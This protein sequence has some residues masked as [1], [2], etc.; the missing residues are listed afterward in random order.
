MK[1]VSPI[2]LSSLICPI[3]NSS[4]QSTDFHLI[5]SDQEYFSC[6]ISYKDKNDEEHIETKY[7]IIIL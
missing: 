7:F 5:L 4:D 2:S 3:I 1:P 6:E